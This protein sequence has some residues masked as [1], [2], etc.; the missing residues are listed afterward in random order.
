M[1]YCMFYFTCDRSLIVVRTVMTDRHRRP[2]GD[3]LYGHFFQLS[4][5]I[6]WLT[7]LL[8]YLLITRC[9]FTGKCLNEYELRLYTVRSKTTHCE[10]RMKVRRYASNDSTKQGVLWTRT[11]TKRRHAHDGRT[12]IS[13]VRASLATI[14]DIV[15]APAAKYTLN[16]SQRIRHDETCGRIATTRDRMI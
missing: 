2:G 6:W 1:F 5:E 7:Y 16:S 13:R 14:F 3:A 4:Y 10:W 12:Q 8:T 15:T 9:S 11:T